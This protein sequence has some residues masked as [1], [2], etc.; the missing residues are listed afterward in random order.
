MPR[1]V[2]I[3]AIERPGEFSGLTFLA[4]NYTF[5]CH[6]IEVLVAVV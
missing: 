5:D 3:V 1:K 2:S 4:F 6:T